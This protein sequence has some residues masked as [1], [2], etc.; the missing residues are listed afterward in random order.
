[1]VAQQ[2]TFADVAD[3]VMGALAGRVF[4]AHNV[5]FDWLFVAR[6]MRRCRDIVLDGPRLCTV[7]LSRR[8][9]PGLGSRGL[10]NVARYFGVEI[11]GR[12]RAAGDAMATAA[13]LQHLIELA[14]ER[15]AT[16]LDELRRL[17]ER[18]RH[19]R[20]ALPRSMDSV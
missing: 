6:E 2:P 4:V 5:R 17:G 10:D 3:D 15:G 16:T 7:Q 12:H 19:K 9:V 1:M 20:S 18:R 8:M 14:R 13:V 11:R